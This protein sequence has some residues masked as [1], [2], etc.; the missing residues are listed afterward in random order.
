MRPTIIGSLRFS[1]WV[2]LSSRDREDHEKSFFD[3]ELKTT[4]KSAS[5]LNRYEAKKHM[6]MTLRPYASIMI[7]IGISL[8]GCS[9]KSEERMK[10]S[11]KP[12]TIA[13][14]HQ[15]NGA[16]TLTE[17]MIREVEEKYQCRLPDDYRRFLLK[18]NGGF[19]VPD[20]VTFEEAGRMTSSDVSCFHS[21]GDKRPWASIEWNLESLAERLPK[22]IIPIAHDSCGNLWLLNVDPDHGGSVIFWDHGSFDTFDETDFDSWPIVAESFHEFF[23]NLHEYEAQPEEKELNSRYV[24]VQKAIKGMSQQSPGFDKQAAQGY[25]WQFVSQDGSVSMECVKYNYH[26]V[27]THT[28][29]YSQLRAEQGWIEAGLTRIPK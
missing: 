3:Q 10:E 27:I 29:G 12:T 16:P 2:R 17:D 6:T 14:I 11:T 7:L 13:T 25:V 24:L 19:P 15:I 4:D 21:I 28:D 9:P 20:C 22:D 5:W 18:N 26:A 1:L 8:L 23:H